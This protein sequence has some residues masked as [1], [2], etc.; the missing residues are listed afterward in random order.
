VCGQA[1][2]GSSNFTSEYQLRMLSRGLPDSTKGYPCFSP[3]SLISHASISMNLYYQC[4]GRNHW[5]CD[6]RDSGLIVK[7]DPSKDYYMYD[8][9]RYPSVNNEDIFMS[10]LRQFCVNLQAIATASMPKP[11]SRK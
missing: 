10:C 9:M 4:K 7:T 3:D 1:I 8:A 2:V 11:W 5:N 6:F